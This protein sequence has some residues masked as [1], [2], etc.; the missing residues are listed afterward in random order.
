[1]GGALDARGIASAENLKSEVEGD[2]EDLDGVLRITRIRIKYHIRIP[3]GTRDKAER[4]LAGY[5]DKCPA[6]QSVKE[7]IAVTW[8]ADLTEEVG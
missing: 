6:Y 3:T 1:M 5:A 7:C 4:A 8:E 2:I